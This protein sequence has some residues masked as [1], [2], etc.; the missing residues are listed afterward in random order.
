MASVCYMP[1]MTNV[2]VGEHVWMASIELRSDNNVS[3]LMGFRFK[4]RRLKILNKINW[5]CAIL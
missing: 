4:C 1:M 3:R 5:L 2:I